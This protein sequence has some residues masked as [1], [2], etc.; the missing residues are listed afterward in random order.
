MNDIYISFLLIISAILALIIIVITISFKSYKLSKF[1]KKKSEE[2]YEEIH[3]IVSDTISDFKLYNNLTYW[4]WVFKDNKAENKIVN[5]HK[6][7]L[8]RYV[9]GLLFCILSITII[10][11]YLSIKY[12]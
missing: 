1:I 7:S 2:R 4:I 10:S 12:D 6:K 5:K 3:G 8:R 11:I 9:Y